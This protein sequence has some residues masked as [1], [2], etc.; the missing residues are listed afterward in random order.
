[1]IQVRQPGEEAVE[2]TLAS[3][4]SRRILAA[5]IRRPLPVKSISDEAEIPLATTY[6]H[7]AQMVSDGMLVVERSAMTPDG[8]PYDLYRSVI[9]LGRVEVGPDRVKISWELNAAIEDKIM[10]M[11]NQL[12]V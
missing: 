4:T 11:W 10:Q 12:G 1:M 2:R 3:R 7:V 6:R 5:C 8:K 9:R